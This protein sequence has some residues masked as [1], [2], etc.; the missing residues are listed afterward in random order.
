M[1]G[2]FTNLERE[3]VA[4]ADRQPDG[5]QVQSTAASRRRLRGRP[6]RIAAVAVV[7]VAVAGGPAVAISGVLGSE[8]D[9]L[10]RL[11]E[12]RVI[13]QGAT[14]T[15]GPWELLASQSDVGFCFGIKIGTS[16]SEG[17]GG[18]SP[19]SLTV[20]TLSGGSIPVEGLA[21]GMAPDAAD[22][23]VVEARGVA[24]TVQTIDDSAGLDG[25]FYVAELPVRRSLG[26][27]RVVAL[28]RDHV[29]VGRIT[30]GEMPTD[31]P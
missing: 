11:S 19:G 6:G 23:V 2:Y 1:T 4:A 8:P 12:R 30:T 21:F 20:A 17:C 14:P 27:T 29:P 25:R 18:G 7:L 22:R 16:V 5:S 26:S 24:V 31:R 10:T 9:G 13:A 3:L 15:R 28:D